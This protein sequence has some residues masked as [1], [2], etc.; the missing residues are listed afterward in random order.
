MITNVLYVITLGSSVITVVS[1]VITKD[2]A[3]INPDNPAANTPTDNT[4]NAG[5][6]PWI[7]PA[8][9]AVNNENISGMLKKGWGYTK[10]GASY[11]GEKL[12]DATKNN[13]Y[14]LAS[15]AILT[16]A[17]GTGIFNRAANLIPYFKYDKIRNYPDAKNDNFKLYIEFNN[18]YNDK[19]ENPITITVENGAQPINQN[20]TALKMFPDKQEEGISI[21]SKYNT[22]AVNNIK[23]EDNHE[24]LS[25][26]T[27]K[28][29]YNIMKMLY[30]NPRY[31][32]KSK[33]IEA[34]IHVGIELNG[35]WIHRITRRWL[36]PISISCDNPFNPSSNEENDD[37]NY[38]TD[39]ENPLQEVWVER[40]YFISIVIG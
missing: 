7:T 14:G 13:G 12:Y 36:Q 20:N 1:T 27:E 39:N 33:K 32:K 23:S 8:L 9:K 6:L 17:Y 31:L 2:T 19:L 35:G 28:N 37:E 16:G 11:V 10:D 22:T 24:F 18:T 3:F 34:T 30:S 26:H 25:T 5:W 15:A 29:L 40:S 38:D 21:K 4:D